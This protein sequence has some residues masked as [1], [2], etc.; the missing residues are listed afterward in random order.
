MFLIFVVLILGI[1]H[2][3]KRKEKIYIL[4]IFLNIAFFL[5]DFCC[6]LNTLV[7]LEHIAKSKLRSSKFGK[8]VLLVNVL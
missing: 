8:R 1:H 2:Y 6:L 5:K 4:K 7:V 3:I